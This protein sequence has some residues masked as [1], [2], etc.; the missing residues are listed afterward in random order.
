MAST[1][2]IVTALTVIKHCNLDDTVEIPR[3]A[4]GVEGSSIYLREG[5]HLTVR[6]LLYGLMLRS[7]NDA[8]VALALHTSGSVEA[9]AALMNEVA[10]EAGCVNSNFVN[11]HGLHDDK[12][13]TTAYDL[14]LISCSALENDDFREIVSTK[15][16]RIRNEGYEYDRVLV[17]KNKLLSN[18]AA[19]DGVK[20]GY[21]KK[22]GRCF[23]GSATRNGMQVVVAVLN[24][25]PMFEDTASMLD[26]AFETYSYQIVV[27]RARFA[28]AL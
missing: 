1:T 24:C 18:Y 6:E 5:E 26:A 25:G 13:Y 17:N 19:A 8:A 16:V 15:T 7:G 28:A 27:P 20:T 9:F 4:V 23:V 2:K 10:E 3:Q 14:A 22:A 21:T 12:H 11:P